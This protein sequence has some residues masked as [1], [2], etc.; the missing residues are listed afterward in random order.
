MLMQLG[1]FLQMWGLR[2]QLFV[3]NVHASLTANCCNKHCLHCTSSR[4]NCCCV[5]L[6]QH[7]RQADVAGKFVEFF[8]SGVSQLSVADRTTIAN[9]CPEYGAILSFFPVDNVTLKHL[10]HTGKD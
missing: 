1:V 5:F 9:M 8:G 6:K 4:N 7:L 10:K 2:F 3:L